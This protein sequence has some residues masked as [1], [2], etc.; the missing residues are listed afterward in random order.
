MTYSYQIVTN[1]CKPAFLNAGDIS[2]ERLADPP[3]IIPT[4]AYWEGLEEYWSDLV[5]ELPDIP[6]GGNDYFLNKLKPSL[7]VQPISVAWRLS[8]VMHDSA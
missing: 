2:V 4:G 3:I 1:A 8:H 6:N 7:G 5:N